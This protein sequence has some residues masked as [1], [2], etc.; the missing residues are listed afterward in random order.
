MSTR[1]AQP[2][3]DAMVAGVTGLLA[4]HTGLDR[5]V[6]RAIFVVGLIL[7]P[8][9][10]SIVYF[11]ISCFL[12]PAEAG[13][14]RDGAQAR[15]V[16]ATGAKSFGRIASVAGEVAVGVARA[17]VVAGR[18]GASAGS[19]AF[20]T[21]TPGRRSQRRAF[22]S[23]RRQAKLEA[24]LERRI[25]KAAPAPAPR[26]H[27][28]RVAGTARA[29]TAGPMAGYAPAPS[30][31]R[32]TGASAPSPTRVPQALSPTPPAAP[33]PTRVRSPL[34]EHGA[35]PGHSP[36]PR[37]APAPAT[38]PSRAPEPKAWMSDEERL[39][40]QVHEAVARQETE[41][42]VALAATEAAAQRA[43]RMRRRR[44]I[45]RTM[46]AVAVAGGAIWLAGEAN[47][48]LVDRVTAGIQEP[49]T[50]AIVLMAAGLWLVVSSVRRR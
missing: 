25:A 24:R 1:I 18:A 11:G 21:R 43:V 14:L 19:V 41:A 49:M 36:A 34:R 17:A 29:A 38:A 39:E 15:Q 33:L 44:R 35:A 30:R 28:A 46:G 7:E 2:D 12:E 8:I 3:P 40:A 6:L 47:L 27:H 10:T 50:M 9:T 48:F 23:A 22:K 32:R 42:R 26:M 37:S 5:N 31:G 4:G 13:K 16:A 20:R 45:R